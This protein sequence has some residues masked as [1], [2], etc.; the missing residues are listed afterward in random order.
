MGEASNRTFG[1]AE[2]AAALH[3]TSIIAKLIHKVDAMVCPER[4]A[5]GLIRGG[6]GGREGGPLGSRGGSAGELG[7]RG[8]DG[9]CQGQ[10]GGC[11]QHH[12]NETHQMTARE[13]RE[14][15]V[16]TVW[17]AV[18]TTNSPRAIILLDGLRNKQ[19]CKQGAQAAVF[20]LSSTA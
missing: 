6:H 9:I 7:G 8:V 20:T 5:R 19:P 17:L 10:R 4:G 11:P 1:K 2:E 15:W 14:V 12:T 16:H 13:W 3:R 18:H